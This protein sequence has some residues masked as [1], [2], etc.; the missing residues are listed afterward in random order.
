MTAVVLLPVVGAGVVP[1]S[2]WL[3]LVSLCP[4]EK[5]KIHP[6]AN[7]IVLLKV[8][9]VRLNSHRLI[10]LR[11]L[12]RSLVSGTVLFDAPQIPAGIQSFQWIPVEWDWNLEKIHR[13]ETESSGMEPEST[14]MEP[15][16]TGM[17]G[18]HRNDW[19][20]KIIYLFIN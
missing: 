10:P 20:K 11:I 6:V 14:G 7:Y 2:F 18:F 3:F 12:G 1:L 5:R 8:G 9:C 19:K 15:E 16:S 13:N 17:T 4:Q